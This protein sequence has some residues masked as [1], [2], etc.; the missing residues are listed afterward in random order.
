MQN[1]WTRFAKLQQKLVSFN[2]VTDLLKSQLEATCDLLEP[3]SIE[4]S[5]YNRNISG[6]LIS[7]IYFINKTHA[8]KK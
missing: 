5:K 7:R 6:N 2:E 1:Y 8:L 4:L 3:A